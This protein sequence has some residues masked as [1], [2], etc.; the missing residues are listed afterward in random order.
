VISI[1]RH[2]GTDPID[3]MVAA[4]DH[5]GCLVVTGLADDAARGALE[6]ELQRHLEAT[7][8]KADDPD[9]FYPGLTQRVTALVAR[10][11][12]V[13]ELVL[14]PTVKAVCDH[15]LGPNS[16]DGYQL[17]VT[18]ALNVGPG[19]RAQVLHREEDAFTFF[20]L[21]RPDLVVATMWAISEFRADNGA[22]LLVPGSHRWDAD[23]RPAPEEIVA[24]E[25]PA[26]SLLFWMGGTLHGAGAN[27]SDEWRYGVILTYSAGWLR[28]EENQS[29]AVPP[30]VADTLSPELQRIIGYKMIGALGFHDRR[31]RAE[32]LAPSASTGS[33]PPASSLR[34]I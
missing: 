32:T 6:A 29:L 3:D 25:M 11:E 17:H 33:V 7:P 12:Q 27:V 5:A 18:A 4:L 15:F 1:P 20:P 26:G 19:A 22:T 24:A 34:R 10:S 28:Q 31:I 21:P 16:P 2:A 8:V 23:R 14:H 9:A 30:D 13:R